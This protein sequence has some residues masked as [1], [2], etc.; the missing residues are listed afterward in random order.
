MVY[1]HFRTQA[2]LPVFRDWLQ[3]AKPCASQ[4]TQILGGSLV[5]SMGR[6][7]AKALGRPSV[8]VGQKPGMAIVSLALGPTRTLS[9]RVPP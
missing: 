3:Q 6:L 5:V 9:S 1:V 8:G 2:P 4:P 7:L